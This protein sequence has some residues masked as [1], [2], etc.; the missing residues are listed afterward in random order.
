[1]EPVVWLDAEFLQWESEV[2]SCYSV[3]AEPVRKHHAI[4]R[5]AESLLHASATE[6][7]LSSSIFQLN[8]VVDFRDKHLND[9]YRFRKI[10][11]FAKS[12]QSD[13]MEEMGIVKPLMRKKLDGLRNRVM[14]IANEPVPTLEVCLELSEFVWYYLRATDHMALSTAIEVVFRRG[15]AGT[16]EDVGVVICDVAPKSWIISVRGILKVG[17]L[18]ETKGENSF[19]VLLDSEVR[20]GDGREHFSGQMLPDGEFWRRFGRAYF[21]A[22]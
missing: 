9:C 18:T 14:H 20:R 22:V 21:G 3:E 11:G 19:G 2:D 15:G 8:R 1:M 6:Y 17:A 7:D 16:D 5:H 12:N 13:I 10:P 4:L